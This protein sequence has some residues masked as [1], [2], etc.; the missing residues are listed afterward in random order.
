MPNWCANRLLIRGQENEIARVKQ[1]LNDEGY[2][3]YAR[4]EAEGIQLLMAGCA[5]LLRPVS[6][7]G[8]APYPA[9]TGEGPGDDTPQNR[10]FT[11]WLQLLN[12]QTALTEAACATLHELWLASGISGRTW[13]TL[14]GVQQEYIRA[15][16][17]Q[18]RHD[19]SG[20]FCINGTEESW[21]RLCRGEGYTRRAPLL[22]MQL[23]LPTRL[24]VEINGFNGGL[25]DGVPSGYSWYVSHYGVKWPQAFVDIAFQDA[26]SVT[27]D[28]DTPWSPPAEAVL[29]AMSSRYGV[30]IEHWYAEAGGSFCGRATYEGGDRTLVQSAELEWGEED[31]DGGCEVAGPDWIMNN[32]AHFGG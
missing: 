9:L 31:E 5:G 32:V 18:K 24:D 8:Y 12:D 15:L 30:S 17:E 21:N 20:A 10:A 7:T 3:A 28:F 4:A 13:D 29:S 23:L 16:W 11:Q 14:T 22:D 2:P 25:L 1:L 19:W 27:V 26:V 6:A